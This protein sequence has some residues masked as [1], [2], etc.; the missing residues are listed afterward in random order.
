MR[1]GRLS[2]YRFVFQ[3]VEVM[4][5]AEVNETYGDDGLA[6]LDSLVGES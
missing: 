1:I 2:E 6:L 3:L 5:E 4:R